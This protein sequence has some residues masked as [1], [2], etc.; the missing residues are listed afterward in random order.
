VKSHYI[1]PANLRDM[2]HE[3]LVITTAD[4]ND[5]VLLTE[6]GITIFRATFAPQNRQEDMDKY[7]VD[8]M[9]ATKIWNE[10]SDAGN[11]FFIVWLNGTAIGYAKMRANKGTDAP[12][13]NNPIEIER[14]YVLHEY[15]GK[16]IGAALMTHC[17]AT[18][19]NRSC[20]VVWLGVWEHNHKAID[21]YKKWGFE[22]YGSHVFRL[23]DDDQTDV[24]MKYVF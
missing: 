10:L 24:L 15:H 3:Q 22:L 21:F 20:D 23:G 7:V 12:A 1:A 18:A 14:F 19:R 4:I 5:A 17:L 6:L 11:V 8:E 2:L 13:S 16:K 9:N